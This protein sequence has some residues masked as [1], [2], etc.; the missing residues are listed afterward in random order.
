MTTLAD[1]SEM[2]LLPT[3]AWVVVPLILLVVAVVVALLTPQDAVAASVPSREPRR[4][5]TNPECA[6]RGHH[7]V[8]FGDGSVWLCGRDGCD[9]MW[10]TL[11]ER[12][13]FDQE[14]SA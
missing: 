8:R 9:E 14:A 1:A 11:P 7:K 13:V 3:W 2:A 5:S 4:A 10:M 12:D 6:R